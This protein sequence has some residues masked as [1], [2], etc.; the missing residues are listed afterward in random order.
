MAPSNPFEERGR[1]ALPPSI[2]ARADAVMTGAADQP[3]APL[4]RAPRTT[5]D[6]VFCSDVSLPASSCGRSVST[7]ASSYLGTTINLEDLGEDDEPL[8]VPLERRSGHTDAGAAN[9][10]LFREDIFDRQTGDVAR[11]SLELNRARRE[12]ALLCDEPERE[13]TGKRRWSKRWSETK[14]NPKNVKRKISNWFVSRK[15]SRLSVG[16]GKQNGQYGNLSSDAQQTQEPVSSGHGSSTQDSRR[17]HQERSGRSTGADRVALLPNYDADVSASASAEEDGQWITRH[18]TVAA[19]AARQ[20]VPQ[21]HPAHL[22]WTPPEE[23][24]RTV[25][26]SGFM[27]R[28]LSQVNLAIGRKDARNELNTRAIA[29][30]FDAAY[31]NNT[32]EEKQVKAATQLREEAKQEQ[33][34]RDEEFERGL[35]GRRFRAPRWL[36]SRSAP[37]TKRDRPSLAELGAE[38]AFVGGM[39]VMQRSGTINLPI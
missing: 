28:F 33:K 10:T 18:A 20:T 1:H 31:G 32:S 11:D 30:K 26:T 19:S 9:G 2:E 4:T 6:V 21:L 12:E 29:K 17:P 39:P 14:F 3:S 25:D 35:R 23:E 5:A 7:S 8:M 38:L 34:R 15:D 13:L 22:A 16:D 24:M 27:D 36:R 37:T